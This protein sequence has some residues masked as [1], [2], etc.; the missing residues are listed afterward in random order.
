MHTTRNLLRLASA[1]TLALFLGVPAMAAVPNGFQEANIGDPEPG[2]VEVADGVWTV[3]GYGNDFN[4]QPED[5]LYFIYQTIRGNGSVQARLLERGSGS[6]YAGVMIRT[7]TDANAP[8]AGLIMS[9]S[10][11]NWMVRPQADENATRTSGVSEQTYPKQMM[12]QRVGNTVTGYISEDGKLW[13]QIAGPR[14]LP[15]GDTAVMGWP[16]RIA[17]A[18]APRWSSTASR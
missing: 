6:Q 13:R 8:M 15:L 14:E 4:N 7:S 2:T 12:V 5:Q 1:A 9:T 16:C 10:A 17:G 3:T 11:L 18:V